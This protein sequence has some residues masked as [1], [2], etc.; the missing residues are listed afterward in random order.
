MGYSYQE[1]ILYR[2]SCVCLLSFCLAKNESNKEKD[3]FFNC[4]AEKRSLTLVS[5]FAYHRHA[6]KLLPQFGAIKLQYTWQQLFSIFRT[7]LVSPVKIK[8]RSWAGRQ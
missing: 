3:D 4:S 7:S 8:A 2:L 5:R 1:I 6:L